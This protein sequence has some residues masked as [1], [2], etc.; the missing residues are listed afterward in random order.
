MGEV[1]LADRDAVAGAKKRVALKLVGLDG[2]R[3]RRRFAAEARF[4]LGMNHPHVVQTFDA[5]FERGV[6]YLAMEYVDGCD[7]ADL[8][9]RLGSHG[10]VF[11]IGAVVHVMRGVLRGL[12]YTH[13]RSLVHRDVTPHNV[14][15]GRKGDVK[16]SDFG[17]AIPIDDSTLSGTAGKAR[18][19]APEVAAGRVPTPASDVYG[20]G[21]ILKDLCGAAADRGPSYRALGRLHRSMLDAV[22]QQRVGV[23]GALAALDR[24]DIAE[25]AS[26]VAEALARSSTARSRSFFEEIETGGPSAGSGRTIRSRRVVGLLRSLWARRMSRESRGFCSGTTS[27]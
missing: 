7:L 5:G 4:S 11:P 26:P 23:L 24:L 13:A 19:I 3:G 20:A 16:L 6:G 12:R 2:A 14:L 8:A 15:I 1:W 21:V 22:P 10:E 9:R 27:I 17:V 25:A 18:Y